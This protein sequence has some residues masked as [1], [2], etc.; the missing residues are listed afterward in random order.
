MIR[1]VRLSDSFELRRA[2][3]TSVVLGN[4]RILAGNHRP[5][6]FATRCMMPFSQ[7]H[8]TL[9]Y[10]DRGIRG[11]LQGWHRGTTPEADVVFLA[12][13]PLRRGTNQPTDPDVWYRLVEAFIVKMGSRHVERIFAPIGYHSPHSELFRQ[14]GFH[15]YAQRQVW[16]VLTPDVAEGSSIIAMRPQQRR[17]PHAIQRLYEAITPASVVRC[18][19]RTSRSWQIP[20]VQT[21]SLRQRS[22]VLG[23]DGRDDS[24]RAALHVWIGRSAAVLSLLIDPAERGLASAIVRFGLTQ[25]HAA[26]QGVVYAL[27]PEYHGELAHSLEELS[28]EHIG[29]QRLTVKELTV[30]IRKPALLPI[31]EREGVVNPSL[32]PMSDH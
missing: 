26:H 27:L 5:F 17:D 20:V 4:E 2:P 8:A 23:R 19:Q 21:R 11:Y 1:S 22:W 3:Y 31:L 18:E 25:L 32:S 15:T 30:P 13:Q 9:V 16:R 29:D 14:L 28:F 10:Q 12:S 7:D 24:I 6:R